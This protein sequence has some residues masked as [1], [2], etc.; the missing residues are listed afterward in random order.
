MPVTEY[1]Q[2]DF[3][4]MARAIRR[5]VDEDMDQFELFSL[6]TRYG[7][8]YVRIT[9]ALPEDEPA[10]RYPRYDPPADPGD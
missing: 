6:A 3:D 10:G 5:Y 2:E 1:R 9:M 4:E 7:T 8:A